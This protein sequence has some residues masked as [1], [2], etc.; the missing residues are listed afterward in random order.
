MMDRINPSYIEV[1]IRLFNDVKQHIER[2]W[3]NIET[4]LREDGALL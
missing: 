2:P 1:V 3:S 4:K